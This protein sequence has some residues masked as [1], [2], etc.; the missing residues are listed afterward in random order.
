M[1][2]AGAGLIAVQL[3]FRGWASFRGWFYA[4]DFLRLRDAQQDE[5]GLAYLFRPDNGH[6]MPATRAVYYVFAE[7]WGLSWVAAS[8]VALLLQAAASAAA[9]WMLVV[10]FGARWGVLPPLALYL[11]S[12]M[13]AQAALWWISA[14]NQTPVQ[15]CVFL[16]VGFWVLYL[17]SGRAV[18][19]AALVATLVWGLLFFQKVLFV[20]P[21]LVV[22]ALAYFS[23]GGPMRRV[24]TVLRGYWRSAVVVGAVAGGYTVAYVLFVS[25]P[26]SEVQAVAWADLTTN[27]V[28]TFVVGIT[29]GPWTWVDRPGGA[30][31]DP[32]TWYVVLGWCAALLTVVAS[33]VL[34][35]R[36]ARAWLLLVGYYAVLIGIVGS[37]R[38]TIFGSDIGNAYRFQTEGLCIAVLALGLAWMPLRGA[39]ETSEP[40]RTL[41]LRRRQV[42]LPARP[43]S[44]RGRV[45]VAVVTAAVVAAG[46]ISWVRYVASWEHINDARAFVE[47]L[48][49][50]S[51]RLAG[52]EVADREVPASVL[53][54]FTRPDNKLSDI[55]GLVAP[56]FRFPDTSA[57][58]K[59]VTDTATVNQALIMPTRRTGP[60]PVPDC[61]WSV[62]TGSRVTV[63]LR[64][65]VTFNAQWARIGYFVQDPGR[66]RIDLAGRSV[67]APVAS[68]PNSLYIRVGEDVDG[69]EFS[70]LTS[71]GSLCVNVIEVGSPVPGPQL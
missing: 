11:S 45:L 2:L 18:P 10:L 25:S 41:S 1:L 14:L 48:R 54:E 50:E 39:A 52:V 62:E 28:T 35:R 71:K 16:S 21:V 55:A 36:A 32:P 4:D 13:T 15:M 40:R 65:P 5:W 24:T 31:A 44:R 68:G 19:L 57:R 8:V 3:A 37:A 7:W 6:L 56:G 61:G 67:F 9:L 23:S 64:A 38:A 26:R 69:V 27:M 34:R 63:P 60:G 33:V 30:W 42:Q 49:A 59:M 22:I 70:G 58:L 43:L 53:D 20:L 46:T 29:G 12:A 17:R 66:V 51:E 47:P